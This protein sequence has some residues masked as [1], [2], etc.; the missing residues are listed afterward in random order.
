MLKPNEQKEILK[1]IPPVF[2]TIEATLSGLDEDLP[3]NKN[4]MQRLEVIKAELR[5]FQD[6][7]VKEFKNEKSTWEYSQTLKDVKKTM[8]EYNK[9]IAAST[10]L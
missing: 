5:K 1:L 9:K 10:H 6:T 8:N 3:S 4:I 2:D 7:L